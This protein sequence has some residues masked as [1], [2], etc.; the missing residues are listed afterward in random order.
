MHARLRDAR[1]AILLILMIL[2]YTIALKSADNATSLI[3]SHG[4]IGTD[5]RTKNGERK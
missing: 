3:Y 4:T 5:Q 1:D 2:V